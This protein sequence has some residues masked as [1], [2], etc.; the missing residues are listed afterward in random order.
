MQ[1][2]MPQG[3]GTI[4]D[5][6]DPVFTLPGNPVSAFVS[7][8]VF[9]RPALRKMLGVAPA[10]AARV[11]EAVAAVDAALAGGQAAVRAGRAGSR[12]RTGR[13]LVTPRRRAGLAPA[14]RPRP[15]ERAGR[16]PRGRHRGRSAARWSTSCCS[17]VARA[18]RRM[19][20]RLTHLDEH[21]RGPHGR[22]RRPRTS[23]PARRPPAGRVRRVAGGACALLRGDGRAQGR[24]AR[25]RPDRRHPGR[26]AHPR[27]G[28]AVPPDRRCTAS[29][30]T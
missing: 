28:P 7:F 20:E 29:T 14:R 19:A 18:E 9:V 3:F 4:G 8:E 15:R 22:R 23:P 17:S 26:Q 10:A 12:R 21:G 13:Y 24:R 2:G 11:C 1:P 6:A 27:P 25:R 16:R 30:S 5:E